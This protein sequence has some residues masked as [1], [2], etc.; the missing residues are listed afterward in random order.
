MPKEMV[1][2]PRDSKILYSRDVCENVFRKGDIRVWCKSC[3]A[4][5]NEH[6]E[7]D[8]HQASNA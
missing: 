1:A 2:C 3:E 8:Q 7:P 5:V 4:F 6:S